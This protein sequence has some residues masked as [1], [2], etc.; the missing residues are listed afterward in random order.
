MCLFLHLCCAAAEQSLAS[1]C[2]VL[3]CA[4]G[5]EEGTEQPLAGALEGERRAASSWHTGV[6]ILSCGI[7]L[8]KH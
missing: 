3:L 6:V 5:K 1:Y 4:L 8:L 2:C 7:L